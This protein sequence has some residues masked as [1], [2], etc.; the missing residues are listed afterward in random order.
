MRR[1]GHK[2]PVIHALFVGALM[3][4]FTGC[5]GSQ[6]AA[7]PD[8]SEAEEVSIGYGSVDKRNLTTAVSKV[9]EEQFGQ[10]SVAHVAELLEGKVAGVQVLRTPQGLRVQVRGSGSMYGH[11]DPLFVVDGM[12]LH[13]GVDALT[14]LN[15]SDVEKIEVL[16]DAASTA[17]YGSRG[18]NGVIL[19]TTKDG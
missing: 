17:I 19:I 8:P 2:S 4:L 7:E 18:A 12:P 10:G 13:G 3:L 1:T 16:K 15:P 5:Y 9:T 6:Q 14:G 11:R